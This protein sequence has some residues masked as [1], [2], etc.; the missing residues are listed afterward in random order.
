MEPKNYDLDGK[1]IGLLT[2]LG[3]CGDPD[4]LGRWKSKWKCLCSCGNTTIK[5]TR[6]LV[7]QPDDRRSCGCLNSRAMIG[8]NSKTHGEA[9]R[10]GGKITKEY[11]TWCNMKNRCFNQAVP[12]YKW[13]G[14]RGI[15]V[16]TAWRASYATFLADMGRCPNKHTLERIDN[17]KSY[18]K[19]N[20]RWASMPEQASNRR[21]A[22]RIIFND[23]LMSINEIS[24]ILKR[25]YGTIYYRHIR[26][27]DLSTGK[28]LTTE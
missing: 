11:R 6:S 28:K 23:K 21:D 20:C 4:E 18:S 8:I 5:S 13:Y 26:G 9:S 15:T 16:D 12:E 14:A 10:P 22:V 3:K 17:N 27:Q 1:V 19:T 25:P 24:E 7:R 2:V